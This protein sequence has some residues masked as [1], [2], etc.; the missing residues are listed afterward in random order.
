MYWQCLL[1]RYERILSKAIPVLYN[2]LYIFQQYETPSRS[3][4]QFFCNR[5]LRQLASWPF[6][7]SDL[8]LIENLWDE[9]KD[10]VRKAHPTKMEELS[11]SV[12]RQWMAIL[13][14]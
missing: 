11:N 13:N 5:K 1:K 12:Q 7:S 14:E 8:S 9:L 6:Q 2:N 3:T 4:T 10:R